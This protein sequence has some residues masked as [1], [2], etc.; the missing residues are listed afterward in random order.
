[1]FGLLELLTAE[2]CLACSGAAD[3]GVM[4]GLLELL[5]AE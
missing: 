3:G 5:T 4:F 1:M 2:L